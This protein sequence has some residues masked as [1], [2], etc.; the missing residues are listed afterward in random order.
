MGA[1]FHYVNHTKKEFFAIDTLGGGSK[2]SDI[3][4]SLT[5]RAF[6]LLVIKPIPDFTWFNHRICGRWYGNNV[7]LEPDDSNPDWEKI[8][9]YADISADVAVMLYEI[10]GFQPLADVAKHDDN[11]F[12]QLVYL[13][14]TQ[15]APDLEREL[16][17]HFG[18][19]YQTRYNE[20]SA[21]S[22]QQ[23]KNLT[24]KG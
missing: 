16:V 14:V 3:G 13:V 11:L 24:I 6:S 15:Q 21:K 23:P 18:V 8:M 19:S 22:W 12:L 1:Y 20:L 7:A 2:F 4:Y 17:L 9:A 5:A 10:D